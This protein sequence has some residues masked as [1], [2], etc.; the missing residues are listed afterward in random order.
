MSSAWRVT[1]RFKVD[2]KDKRS[3]SH[4]TSL[5]Y[6]PAV[7]GIYLHLSTQV[8]TRSGLQLC[9]CANAYPCVQAS[10]II[11]GCSEASLSAKQ[12]KCL[13][14]QRALHRTFAHRRM[15]SAAADFRDETDRWSR[16][17][18]PWTIYSIPRLLVP[19]YEI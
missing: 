14:Q 13:C 2:L 6:Q 11:A 18:S 3:D 8:I 4:I 19:V 1:V 5:R 7:W 17:V 16:A 12:Q 9:V 10:P 15:V